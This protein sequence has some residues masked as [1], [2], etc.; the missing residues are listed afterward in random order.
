MKWLIYNQRDARQCWNVA[1]TE[2]GG[3][4]VRASLATTFTNDEHANLEGELPEGG[5]WAIV[6]DRSGRPIPDYA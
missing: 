2:Y 4:W 5:M 1:A 3:G 6:G